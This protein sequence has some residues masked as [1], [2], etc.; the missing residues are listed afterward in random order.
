MPNR[1]AGLP[2][3]RVLEPAPESDGARGVRGGLSAQ[4]IVDTAIALADV[5]GLDAVS[6]RRVA[7]ILEVRP[8]SLYTHIASKDELLAM[9]ANELIGSVIVEE[10]LPNEWREA[11]SLIMHNSFRMFASH[12]WLLALLAR[13]PRHGP[14]AAR[15]AKQFAQA[16]ESLRLPPDEMWTA[17]S[18]VNDYVVGHAMRVATTGSTSDLV[19]SLRA[20]DRA[21]LPEVAALARTEETRLAGEVFELGLQAVLDGVELRFVNGR[22]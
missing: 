5:D 10:P 11:L 6:I 14:N 19:D 21:A 2:W 16:V 13:R 9:M 15:Q 18:I 22:R 7:A 8:M 12:P 20:E 17:L 3:D 1:A 4:A